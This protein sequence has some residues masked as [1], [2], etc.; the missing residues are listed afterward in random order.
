MVT[1]HPTSKRVHGG[2]VPMVT[3]RAQRGRMIGS[4][5]STEIVATAELACSLAYIAALRATENAEGCARC[6]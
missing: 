4:R 3:L 6:A 2:Y 1:Y 5:T